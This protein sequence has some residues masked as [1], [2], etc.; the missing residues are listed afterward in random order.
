MGESVLEMAMTTKEYLRAL[1]SLGL[2]PYG[3]ATAEALGVSIPQL[4]R[5]AAGTRK[6]NRTLALLIRLYLRFGVP[7]G[8]G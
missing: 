7:S 3:I 4:A 1:D 2:A 6:V 5:L 8:I